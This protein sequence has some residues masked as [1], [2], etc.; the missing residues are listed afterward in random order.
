M[1]YV[2]RGHQQRNEAS[3]LVSEFLERKRLA[4]LGLQTDLG[5]L[6]AFKA[7]CFLVVDSEFEQ[8]RAEDAKRESKAK[9]KRGR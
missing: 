7:D 3:T 2:Y 5:S 9:G 8:L 6:S 1:T 4:V